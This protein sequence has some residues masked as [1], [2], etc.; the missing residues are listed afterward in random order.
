MMPVISLT[1]SFC[2][3]ISS[4]DILMIPSRSHFK[5]DNTK[6]VCEYLISGR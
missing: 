6:L 3:K 4:E 5:S 2:S 1:P